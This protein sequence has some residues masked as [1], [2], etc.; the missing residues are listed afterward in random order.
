MF[1]NLF[2]KRRKIIIGIHGLHN[3]PPRKLLTKWWRK[4]IREGLL[5]DYSVF[6]PFSFQMVYWS[7]VNYEKPQDSTSLLRNQ[8][9]A[10][11]ENCSLID[12]KI[13]LTVCF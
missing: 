11:W 10:V 3:K 5:R 8:A 12:S 13:L 1:Q 7:D 4:S 2:R 9:K 6:K